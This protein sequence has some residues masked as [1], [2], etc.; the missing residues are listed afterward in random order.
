VVDGPRVFVVGSFSNAGSQAKVDGVAGLRN[1]TWTNVGTNAAGTDG[2][3]T[4]PNPLMRDLAVVGPRLYIGGLDQDIGGGVLN[5]SIAFYRVRQPDNLIK[6]GGSFVGNGVYNTTGLHQSATASAIQG[7]TAT[8]TT[9]ITND[10]FAADSF[11]VKGTGG[12]PGFATT[13]L[14]GATNVTSQVVAGTYAI[15][16][17]AP[18]SSVDITLRVTVGTSVP[19]GTSRSWLVTTTSTGSGT[20]NDGVKATVTAH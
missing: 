3:M 8:F 15:N 6:G 20:P 1:G 12:Q 7:G 18:G 14:R 5:D 13:Y 19:D 11:T 10:G 17:L 9:R 2:P 4:G 16:N